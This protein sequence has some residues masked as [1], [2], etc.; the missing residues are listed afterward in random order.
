MKPTLSIGI[1][2]YNQGEF[3]EKAITS[4]LNQTVQAFEIVVSN[5][6]ST[7]DLT[8]SILDKYS[9]YI[10]VITPPKHLSMMENWNF[11][12][13]HLQGEYISLLSSDDYYEPTFIE[14][15]YNHFHPEYI[16]YRTDFHTVD[17]NE[18]IIATH[19]LHSVNKVQA[20]PGNF[21]EQ[22]NG[23]KVNF[24]G[25]VLKAQMLKE[26]NYFDEH[27]HLFGDW[28]LWLNIAPFGTFFYIDKVLTNYR[29]D[30][31]PKILQKRFELMVSD[32]LHIYTDIQYPI[33]KKY[34]L[35]EQFYKN[36]CRIHFYKLQETAVSNNIEDY[37]FSN[38]L[39]QKCHMKQLSSKLYYKL[40]KQIQGIYRF[41]LIQ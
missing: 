2:T 11:L 5:N 40:L 6:H 20:F 1:P 8:E 41:F 31:R 9:Q 13:K 34:K 21:Y 36:A 23:P 38:L 3:L 25:F 24:A 12:C 14:E 37:N 17:I 26:V 39:E 22:L 18:N 28:G 35:N 4:V 10:T 19:K 27:L 7:D 16:L 32:S 30:Y 15:F 33:I 29:D